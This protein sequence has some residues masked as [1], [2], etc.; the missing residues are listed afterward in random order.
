M[1]Q[2]FGA[3]NS[4]QC[5]GSGRVALAQARCTNELL[6]SVHHISKCI[7]S[8]KWIWERLRVIAL[9]RLLSTVWYIP[10]L[11]GRKLTHCWAEIYKHRAGTDSN[12]KSMRGRLGVWSL[13]IVGLL[14]MELRLFIKE[15]LRKTCRMFNRWGRSTRSE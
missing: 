6:F 9:Y 10:S 2:Y 12:V 15:V 8:I 3:L 5:A 1:F 11:E 14:C 13:E 4:K 7:N